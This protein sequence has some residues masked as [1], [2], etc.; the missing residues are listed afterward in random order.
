MLDFG[1]RCAMWKLEIFLSLRN[2]S[3]KDSMIWVAVPSITERLVEYQEQEASPIL[4]RLEAICV[5]TL[6]FT[7]HYRVVGLRGSR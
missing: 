5:G 6:S 7:S 2:V 1:D 3:R 4:P